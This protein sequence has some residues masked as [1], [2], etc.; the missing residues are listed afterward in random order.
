MKKLTCL[1]LTLCLLSTVSVFAQPKQSFRQTVSPDVEQRIRRIENGLLLPV[2]IKGQSIVPMKLADRMQ[3][4]KTPGVSIAFI[5]N[6]RIEWARAYGVQATG[7]REP[8][9]TE[10]LFQAGSISKPV[11]AMIALQMAQA[12]KFNLDEDVN[13]RLVSWK[14]PENEFTTREK[15][16]VRRIVSHSAGLTNHVAGNYAAGAELPT[17]VQI[18][19]GAKPANTP[20]IRVDLIPGSRWRYSGG[21]YG[22]LQQLIVDVGGKP[23]PKLAQEIIFDPLKMKHSTF[24]Q[25]LP[26]RFQKRATVGHNRAGERIAGNWIAFP[27]M[28][29][30]GLWSTPSDLARFALELQQSKIGKSNKIL[31][32]QMTNQMLTRQIENWGLGFTVEGAGRSARFSHAGDTEGY[33]CLLVMYQNTGQGAVIMTNSDRGERIIP[34]LLRS[35]AREYGWNDFQPKEKTIAK[36]DPKVYADYVGKYQFEFSS[37]FVLTVGT[38]AGNLTT[39]LKQPTGQS[40][41]E[42]FPESETKFFRKDVDIEITFVKDETGQVT[43]LIFLQE[44][45]EFRVRKLK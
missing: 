18:L 31:T 36:I 32:V 45:Q 34:E 26:E 17:L 29:A 13:R 39:E 10:T 38:E 8:V 11:T 44:G 16:T 15:V 42:L 4:Y 22:V 23:F 37:D 7:S 33:K 35:I 14:V 43:H 30:A 9:T 12:S 19:D 24:E 25:P 3:F 40:K 1:F 41:T 27:E 20:P 21:G 5:N 2:A 28:A 6:G